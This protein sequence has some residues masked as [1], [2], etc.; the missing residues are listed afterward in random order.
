MDTYITSNIITSEGGEVA[1]KGVKLVCPPGAV[2]KPVTITLSLEDPAKH[3][4][5]IVEKDLEND[6]MIAA[7]VINLQPNGLLFKKPVTLITNFEMK[8]FNREDV[9][10]LEGTEDRDG[11][12]VWKDITLDSKLSML[13]DKSAEVIIEMEHFTL[14]EIVK[15]KSLKEFATKLNLQGFNYTISAL[16]NKNSMHEQLALLFV[17]QYV[18][19]QQSY[20]ENEASAL[21]QL[22]NDGFTEL[23]VRSTNVQEEEKRVY[24]NEKLHI[25][26]HLEEDYNLDDSEQE[27]VS[28]TVNSHNW[29]NA[30]EV[31]TLRLKYTED[32][33][34]LCGKI[35]IKREDGHTSERH[36]SETGVFDSY[37]ITACY[38]VNSLNLGVMSEVECA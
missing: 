27:T 2:N 11:K 34:I 3:Y 16:H 22:Q 21:V 31:R 38:T 15:S 23:H 8:D 10:I 9:F 6:V 37:N 36:F 35:R 17:S 30:G 4:G 33:R 13:D 28:I 12:I 32:A 1:G 18:Y 24:N 25:S 7:P 29:W 19:H 26:I 14:Y 20:K 5:R